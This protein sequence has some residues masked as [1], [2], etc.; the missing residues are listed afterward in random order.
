MRSSESLRRGRSE[1]EKEEE[2]KKEKSNFSSK[3]LNAPRL[4]PQRDTASIHR[5]IRIS[6][7]SSILFFTR[8]SM[9]EEAYKEYLERR[10][11]F[12]I[13]SLLGTPTSSSSS[14]AAAA[15]ITSATAVS[16][17]TSVP[18]IPFPFPPVTGEPILSQMLMTLSQ[19]HQ[20]QL[21]AAAAA[22][23]ISAQAMSSS[24]SNLV[25]QSPNL[26]KQEEPDTTNLEQG[27]QIE[28]Y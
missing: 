9:M 15:S 20:Q 12:S 24:A 8:E 3:T 2:R 4:T 14:P 6:R 22:A 26:P 13:D 18:P 5:L 16:D 21:F 10:C 28:M 17:I 7:F 23:A 11:A 19:R 1:K 27:K 25:C